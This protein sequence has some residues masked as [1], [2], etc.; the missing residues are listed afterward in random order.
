ML[1]MVGDR[2]REMLDKLHRELDRYR[3]VAGC[4]NDEPVALMELVDQ[5]KDSAFNA[6]VTAWHLGDWVFNDMTPDQRRAV[7][8]KTLGDLQTHA[9]NSCRA[10]YLCRYAATAS[11]HSEVNSHPDPKVNVVVSCDDSGW[12]AHFVDDGKT[13]PADQVFAEALEFWTGFIYQ[14][15]IGK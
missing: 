11:K 15:R 4:D 6:A 10:L 12:A 5:L 13:R 1:L 2:L 8:V 7:G 9:R 14:N 3:E